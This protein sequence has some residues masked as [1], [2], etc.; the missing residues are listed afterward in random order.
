MKI[1]IISILAM[2]ISGCGSGNVENTQVTSS[3]NVTTL[4]PGVTV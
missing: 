1:I 4:T 3:T 2:I